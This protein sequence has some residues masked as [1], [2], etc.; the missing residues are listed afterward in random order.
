MKKLSTLFS[1]IVFIGVNMNAYSQL[2]GTKTIPGDYATIAA[3]ITDLNSQGV[4]TGGVTFDVAA[5]HTEVASNLVIQMITNPP[6]S[7]NQVVF[8]KSGVGPNPLISAAPGIGPTMDAV[9]KLV[10]A[11]Y[12]TIDRIDLVDPV[13][14]TGDA[15]M[16]W[17]YVLLRRDSTDGSQHNTIRNCNIN[18][19]KINTE[20]IGIYFWNRTLAGNLADSGGP[21]GLNSY[22]ILYGNNISDVDKGIM[23]ESASNDRDIDNQVGVVGQSPNMITNFGGSIVSAVSADGIRCEGQINVKINNNIINGGAGT[24]GSSAV[25]GIIATLFGS[26]ANLTNYEISYNTITIQGGPT[27]QASYGI[28]ALAT[29]DTVRIHHNTVE[30][31]N[32]VQNTAQYR[33]ISHDPTGNTNVAYM[34]DNIVRNNTF[35]GTGTMTLLGFEGGTLSG[36]IYNNEVY[37]NQKTGASGSIFC[38][39][40][41]N[42]S[43]NCYSNL[44]HDNSIPSSSGSS[45]SIVY[46]Y[47]N[48][49]SDPATEIV[50]DNKFY[51]LSVGGSGTSSSNG[52]IGI[53]STSDP[54]TNKDFH[55]NEIYG[56]T[57]IG[58]SSASGGVAGIWSTQ[59]TSVDIHENKIY[60][61]SNSGA[62]GTTSGIWISGALGTTVHSVDGNLIFDLKAPNSGN[63]NAVMGFNSTLSAANSSIA[64]RDNSIHLTASGGSTFGS[65]GVSVVGSATATTATLTMQNNSIMN[66][67]TPGSAS[68]NV[69]AYRRSNANL[70][71]YGASSD[72]NNF[73]AGTPAANRLIFFDGINSDQTIADYKPR[74]DPRDANSVSTLRKT[75]NLAVNFEACNETDTIA[76]VIRSSVVPYNVIDSTVGLGGEGIKHVFEID[77]AQDSVNYYVVVR[78]RNSI[79][80]WS[81][82]GGSMF[83]GGVLNYSFTT[84]ASQAFGNNMVLVGSMY[85]LFTGDVQQDGSVDLSD[86]VAIFNDAGQFATGYVVTDLNCD[87]FVD[88]TD[89][90]FAF[91]N[92]SQFVTVIRP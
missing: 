40:A 45:A 7:G 42:G 34:H 35:L 37:G 16:E 70:A 1:C 49:D 79:E 50:Y 63:A 87:D 9:V 65:S 33:G 47:H 53:R 12:V 15:M 92:S 20:S 6:T 27:S 11:D 46:G 57:S 59:G 64:F 31:C 24:G 22:N 61:L 78:H 17:G 4:G 14:N 85:S 81:K 13:S 19:Q 83:T 86:I 73:Y 69:V 23:L 29:G 3:A 36:Y 30:N 82:S 90:V 58:G 44:V 88:L 43:V 54:L 2:T 80:T 62:T 8:Q 5:G 32:I 10:G 52:V 71:N 28:R 26:S 74:V 51:N 25:F 67:S 72:F 21:S 76:A 77:N 66:L 55:H 68:G 84:A 18:L 91:N 41:A 39:K 38:L 89:I 48:S 56:L 75:L 60:D